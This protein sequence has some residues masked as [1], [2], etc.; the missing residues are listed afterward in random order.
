MGVGRV[1]R[2]RGPGCGVVV[3]SMYLLPYVN[4]V[5]K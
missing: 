2:K 4:R 3:I 5:N 1:N